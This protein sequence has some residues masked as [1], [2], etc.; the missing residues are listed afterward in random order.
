MAEP[1]G[2][3]SSS[4]TALTVSGFKSIANEQRID[5]RPLTVLAGANSSGKSSMLQPLLLLKQTLEAEFLPEALLLDGPNVRFTRIDQLLSSV[6]RR[7]GS[8]ELGIEVDGR[9]LLR[10]RYRKTRSGLGMVSTSVRQDDWS[11]SFTPDM[12]SDEIRRA[13]ILHRP[14]LARLTREAELAGEPYEWVVEPDGGFLRP[15]LVRKTDDPAPVIFPQFPPVEFAHLCIREV[16]HVPAW[17]GSPMRS[18]PTTGA[19]QLFRG[20][21]DNYVASVVAQLQARR[22]EQLA[23]DLA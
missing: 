13:M 9:Y 10:Q 3:S 21:F 6:G 8:F 16:I 18:Y 1:A 4:I 2:R 22:K 14:Q 11:A 5:L 17:R 15:G 7:R 23:G 19:T 20:T 12:Q